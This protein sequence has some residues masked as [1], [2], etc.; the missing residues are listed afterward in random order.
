MIASLTP[1]NVAIM[2]TQAYATPQ[3]V[4]NAVITK[5]CS[6][7]SYVNITSKILNTYPNAPLLTGLTMAKSLMFGGCSVNTFLS[8][9]I[10]T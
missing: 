8:G 5:Q 3:H 6:S 10:C 9:L 4:T 7:Y 1:L 2:S